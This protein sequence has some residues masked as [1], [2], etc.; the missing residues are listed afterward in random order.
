[1]AR[2]RRGTGTQSEDV[3][4]LPRAEARLHPWDW[5]D[6]LWSQLHLDYAG[7]IHGTMFLVLIDAHSKWM[8]VFPVRSATTSATLECLRKTFAIHGLA[9]TIVTDNGSCFTSD[10]FATCMLKNGIQHTCVALYHPASNGLAERV[11]QSFKQGYAKLTG[12]TVETRV[13]RFLFGYRN[14]P[15]S[16]T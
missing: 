4:S 11:V 3:L 10:E 13:S 8:D 14:T 2:Y 16:T 12:G 1:M 9:E 7:P 5:P 6:K 15:Q